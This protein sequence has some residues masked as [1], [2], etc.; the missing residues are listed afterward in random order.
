MKMKR[1]RQT[2]TERTESTKRKLCQATLE[3]ISDVGYEKATTVMIA[4]RAGVSRGAQTHHFPSKFDLV[5]ESF[6]FL[7]RDWESRRERFW[8]EQDAKV[9]P[10]RYIRFLWDEIYGHPQ[11]VASLEMMLASRGDEK[12]HESLVS[13]L[14]ELTEVRE[15]MW[16]RLTPVQESGLTADTSSNL[17]R[18]TMCLLRGLSLQGT[19]SEEDNFSEETLNTWIEM[20]RLFAEHSGS[21]WDMKLSNELA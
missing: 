9:T 13:S 17:M 11:Y 5:T 19:I 1:K 10:E 18:M 2:Q 15:A 16:R 21:E 14:S 3:V 20:I 7:L 6:R 8:Q 12:L 4:E